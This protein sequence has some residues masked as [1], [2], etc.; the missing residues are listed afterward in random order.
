MLLYDHRAFVGKSAAA[1]AFV[2]ATSS[3]IPYYY[4]L[5]NR[6]GELSDMASENFRGGCRCRDARCYDAANRGILIWAP[7]PTTRPEPAYGIISVCFRKAKTYGMSSI[8]RWLQHPCKDDEP[9]GRN[10]CEDLGLGSGF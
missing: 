8:G 1:T 2:C 4:R 6:G 3:A 5:K 7:K 10:L 9:P